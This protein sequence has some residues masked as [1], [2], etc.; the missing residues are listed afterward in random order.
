[1]NII[2]GNE[3]AHWLRDELKERVWRGEGLILW[4]DKPVQ[5]PDWK[6]FLGVTL[7][8]ITGKNRETKVQLL[9]RNCLEKRATMEE[10]LTFVSILQKLAD[11]NKTRQWDGLSSG[12]EIQLQEKIDLQ[13]IQEQNDVV[14]VAQTKQGHFP[15]MSYRKYGKGDILVITMPMEVYQGQDILAQ[16][17]INAIELFSRDIYS[18]TPLTRQMPIEISIKNETPGE[19]KLKVKV[20]LPYGVEFMETEPKPGPVEPGE[21]LEWKVNVP[22]ASVASITGWLLLP[23]KIGTYEVKIEL[24][25]GETRISEESMTW[26]VTRTVSAYIHE[27]IREIE[28]IEAEGKDKQSLRKAEHYLEKIRSRTGDYMAV[29]LLNLQDAVG[30]A[31][32]L[33]EI[34]NIDVSEQR[35]EVQ[36]IM[37]IMGRWY[38]EK[39]KSLIER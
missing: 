39:V 21:E 16:L 38:Y 11:D 8:P 17:L 12:G 3:M 6:D 7:K 37:Y 4:C 36:E 31:G 32:S 18:G 26:E 25:E 27:L 35:E 15:V 9:L 30:A 13:I 10:N 5:N 14:I 28:A 34:K 33:G 22:A 29:Y 20:V 2:I 1:V 19:K 24:Y 23:D